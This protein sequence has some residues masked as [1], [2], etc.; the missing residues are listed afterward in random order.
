M[1]NLEA[2]LANITAIEQ[3]G[4]VMLAKGL[5]ARAKWAHDEVQRLRREIETRI[6]FVM[7]K[8]A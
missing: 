1:M 5:R 4:N 7:P 2:K 6:G 8:A 3:Y